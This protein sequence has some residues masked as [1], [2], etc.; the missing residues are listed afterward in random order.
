MERTPFIDDTFP[1]L[2]SPKKG[3]WTYI[4]IPLDKPVAKTPFG[5]KRVNGSIDDYELRDFT[6][7]SMKDQGHFVAV[8]ADIRKAIG[9]EEGDTVRLVIY[10]DDLP[11]VADDDFITCLKEE[12]KTYAA[13]LAYPDK[14]RRKITDWI[15]EAASDEGKVQRIAEAIDRIAAGFDKW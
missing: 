9:K 2:K 14:K 6:M 4:L 12:K 3:G 8:K 15:A 11:E 7:W 5:M 1:L 10:T 13:F